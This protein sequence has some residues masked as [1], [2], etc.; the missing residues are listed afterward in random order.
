MKHPSRSINVQMNE[1][2]RGKI[3]FFYKIDEKME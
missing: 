3:T 2:N 1:G